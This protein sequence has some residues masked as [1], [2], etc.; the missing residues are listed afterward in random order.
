MRIQELLVE[1][2]GDWANLQLPEFRDGLNVIRVP[3]EE[4]SNLLRGCFELALTTADGTIRPRKPI[5]A[6]QIAAVFRVDDGTTQRRLKIDHAGEPIEGQTVACDQGLP[7]QDV[8]DEIVDALT[9]TFHEPATIDR[10]ARRFLLPAK[11]TKAAAAKR[12]DAKKAKRRLYELQLD[13]E[14]LLAKRKKLC[15]RLTPGEFQENYFQDQQELAELTEQ[16]NRLATQ[17]DSLQQE[18]HIVDSAMELSELWLHREKIQRQLKKIQP[19]DGEGIERLDDLNNR[20]RTQRHLQKKVRRKLRG[21]KRVTAPREPVVD[22]RVQAALAQEDWLY[23]TKQTIERLTSQLD[24]VDVQPMSFDATTTNQKAQ[25][26]KPY[27]SALRNAKR[28][29]Q[30]AERR[31]NEFEGDLDSRSLSQSNQTV[32]VEEF[33]EVELRLQQL[34]TQ[35]EHLHREIEELRIECSELLKRQTMPLR[36]LLALA[37]MF[38]AGI[39]MVFAGLYLEM[40]GVEWALIAMGM[41]AAAAAALLRVSYTRGNNERIRAH[42]RRINL[43]TGAIEDNRQHFNEIKAGNLESLQYRFVVDEPDEDPAGA[44]IDQRITAHLD[45]LVASVDDC[46]ATYDRARRRWEN[47]LAKQGFPRTLSPR[48]VLARF[49]DD[50][51]TTHKMRREVSQQ[52]AEVAKLQSELG[53]NEK[54]LDQWRTGA[55]ELIDQD[56]SDRIGVDGLLS[57][58]KRQANVESASPKADDG[59]AEQLRLDLSNSNKKMKQVARLRRELFEAAD[60]KNESEYRQRVDDAKRRKRLVKDLAEVKSNIEQRLEEDEHGEQVQQ[61]LTERKAADIVQEGTE[62]A[63]LLRDAHSQL[64]Q[65]ADSINQKRRRIASLVDDQQ[66]GA[67]KLELETIE[68]KLG[69]LRRQWQRQALWLK[70]NALIKENPEL[71]K[72]KDIPLTEINQ[73][74]T[75]LTSGRIQGLQLDASSDSIVATEKSGKSMPLQKMPPA[76]RVAVALA[77]R[78]AIHRTLVN[79]QS[80]PLVVGD[81]LLSGLHAE[82]SDVVK[83]LQASAETGLQLFLITAG[84]DLVDACLQ[85]EIPVAFVSR[86]IDKRM[87]VS[88]ASSDP[89][90]TSNQMQPSHDETVVERARPATPI[91]SP[92]Y[93]PPSPSARVDYESTMPGSWSP[94]NKP[95]PLIEPTYQPMSAAAASPGDAAPARSRTV[96]VDYEIPDVAPDLHF[97]A[98]R[99]PTIDVLASARSPVTQDFSGGV[100]H[101]TGTEQVHFDHV[102]NGEFH[103]PRAR[104]AERAK[105]GYFRLDRGTD[106]VP[107]SHLRHADD[108]TK[109]NVERDYRLD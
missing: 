69:E 30:D 81:G 107:D 4:D 48:E 33:D 24:D 60:C 5:Q 95:A 29:L 79:Q 38:A 76:N 57:L 3:S 28:D 82:L 91:G 55:L 34:I 99:F 44:F 10:F 90:P 84:A 19:I 89:Q 16:K 72:P 12:L 39:A 66:S 32:E 20:L 94:L 88:P 43:L 74:L 26:L 53:L 67:T 65:L 21:R 77:M 101:P 106:S 93:L 13:I 96:S 37:A 80:L 23:E 27:A 52:S 25:A 47:A 49:R 6:S 63:N 46:Q 56:V 70:A 42:R 75:G 40:G 78:L 64:Q 1:G 17:C 103:Q 87:L 62:K 14:T 100:A 41:T 83:V 35:R 102:A 98:E 68:T 104:E 97:D 92:S 2:F 22:P 7:W 108:S 50:K 71:S 109:T 31:F 11:Q 51:K 105:F 9:Q 18:H 85:A 45:S 73:I 58:L 59:E 61:L 8:D 36:A 54:W 86:E 15:A